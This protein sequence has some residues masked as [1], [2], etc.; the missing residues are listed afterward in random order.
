MISKLFSLK[1]RFIYILVLILINIIL[2][3]IYSSNSETRLETDSASEI[4]PIE[5]SYVIENLSSKIDSILLEFN[6]KTDWIKTEKDT[7]VKLFSK[8]IQVPRDLS[9][10]YVNREISNL[11][12]RYDL[13]E[14]VNEDARTRNLIVKIYDGKDANKNLV[15]AKLDFNKNRE[16]NRDAA[17]IVLVFDELDILTEEQRRDVLSTTYKFS[18]VLPLEFKKIDVQSAIIESGKNYIIYYLIGDENNYLADFRSDMTDRQWKTRITSLSSEY[19]KASGIIFKNPDEQF[20]FEKNI[21]LQFAKY[22]ENSFRDT[23][24]KEFIPEFND[25]GKVKELFEIIQS[26]NSAGEKIQFYLLKFSYKD[27]QMLFSSINELRKKGYRFVDFKTGMNLFR[28][29]VTIEEETEELT[30]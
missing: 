14:T 12:N 29:I 1:Y 19:P 23:L 15:L 17:S 7:S 5:K 18:F 25:P 8:T 3:L 16:L 11:L 20:E 9:V 27:F 2:Y 13:T 6:L 21:R 10:S 22:N 28:N 4:P 24:I 26:K 30:E